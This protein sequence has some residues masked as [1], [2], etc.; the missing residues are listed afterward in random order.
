MAQQ[1]QMMAQQAATLP[2]DELVSLIKDGQRMGGPPFKQK[3][4]SFCD[5]GW[6][7]TRD[8]DPSHHAQE[9][10]A[11][12]VQMASFEY[13][14]ETW[15]RKHFDDLPDLPPAPPLLPGMPG[16]PGL[17]G[18]G[19]PGPGMPIPPPPGMLPPPPGMGPPSGPNS[20]P[21]SPGSGPGGPGGG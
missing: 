18:G 16:M 9:T 1:Q 11:Q 5:Q 4:W 19:P 20:G 7:G 10:L 3:W 15:F 21:G 17:P 8:Y 6:G 13:G 14:V 12:F 2:K